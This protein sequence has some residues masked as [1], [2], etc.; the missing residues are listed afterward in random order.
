MNY[1]ETIVI[2][3]GP[4]GSTCAWRLNQH[5]KDVLVL[6][7][8]EFPRVKL[9]AGWI[10]PT[11]LRL[12]DFTPDE[13]PHSI[14]KI[15]FRFIIK[16]IPFALPPLG[17][18]GDHYAIR[19]EQWD[20]WLLERSKA[21]TEIHNVRKIHYD[22]ERY[23]IDDKYQC[24]YLVGAGGT[25]C[26]VKRTTFTENK[27]KGYYIVTLEN[28]FPYEPKSDKSFLFFLFNRGIRGYSWVIPKQCGRVNLGLGGFVM[29]YR[30]SGNSI[31]E[32]FSRYTDLLVKRKYISRDMVEQLE[33]TG[34]PYYLSL[35]EDNPVK[36]DNAYVIGDSAGLA[37]VDLGEGL[38]PGIES[39]IAA[40]DEI[41]GKGK[42]ER[43]NLTRYSFENR[44]IT[45]FFTKIFYDF[46]RG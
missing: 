2:G 29:D 32:Y 35:T 21:D 18:K 16:W 45:Y 3:G 33:P 36:K 43:K 40:A 19:R 26:P 17:I 38:G 30:K 9:C 20:H 14:T 10:S 31:R 4:V 1:V 23:T 25:H 39:A 42:Y 22:G 41:A 6:E 7:K 44:V 15:K 8:S 12:L 37:T 13:Y 5:G 11:V 28:E 46:R 27:G 34:H 24:K